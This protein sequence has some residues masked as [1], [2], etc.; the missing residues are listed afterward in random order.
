[1]LAFLR[2]T[3]NGVPSRSLRASAVALSFALATLTYHAVE[4]P[5]RRSITPARRARLAALVAAA[6][7]I[8]SISFYG[9]R[10][11]TLAPRTPVFATGTDVDLLTAKREP[12]CYERFPTLGEYCQESSPSMKVTTALL[13]D[14][15]AEHL[16]TGIGAGLMRKGE[17]VV[18]LGESGCP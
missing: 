6:A 14:S 5:I 16:L 18:H 2:I 3:E 4:K 10:T 12:H 11:N 1:L 13:G 9:Y 15:H 17:S 7:L 8:G